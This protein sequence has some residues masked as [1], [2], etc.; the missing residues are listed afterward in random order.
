[1]DRII[2]FIVSGCLGVISSITYFYLK[3]R[4]QKEYLK[5]TSNEIARLESSIN[6]EIKDISADELRLTKAG[7]E[8]LLLIDETLLAKK[9]K[10]FFLVIAE[11]VVSNLV[12][13]LDFTA[14]VV[15]N[16][17]NEETMDDSL[18]ILVDIN[19]ENLSE[20]IGKKA[21]V[22]N[23]LQF[24]ASLIVS[25]R[26]ERWIQL[27]VDVEGYRTRRESQIKKLANRASIQVFQK[28]E[29]QTLEGRVLD[30]TKSKIAIRKK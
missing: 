15:A 30:K 9:D 8:L 28:E 14:N 18:I 5:F 19:G 26:A 21:E 6:V 12:N 16:Y 20:L 13:K 24:I 4:S 1:M 23:S 17:S 11:D 27:V 2:I 3:F 22:L 7:E 10:D 29:N 25:K